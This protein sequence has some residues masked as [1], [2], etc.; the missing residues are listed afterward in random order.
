MVRAP[1]KDLARV[2]GDIGGVQAQL[3]SAAELQIA[4]RVDCSVEDVRKALWTDRTLVKTWLMRGTLHLARSGDLPF[5]TAAM[6]RRWI[7][8]SNSWLKFWKI[9]E[10]ELWE[11]VD[12]IGAALDGRP[13]TREELIARVGKGKSEELLEALR[14]GWGGMLKPAARNGRL[15]FG[16]NRGQSV[17][18][19]SPREWLP[20]WEEVDPEAG[21]VEMARR[22]LRAFGPATRL[23]FVRWWG[24]WPGVGNAAWSGLARELTQVSIEGAPADMLTA[25]LEVL[26]KAR[27]GESVHLLPLFDPYLLG[28]ANRDHLFERVHASKVSRTAGWISAVVLVNGRV[29]GTWTHTTNKGRLRV[30]VVPFKRFHAGTTAK[31]RARAR[32]IARALGAEKTEVRFG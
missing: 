9:T 22:Y 29:E 11:L 5:Y 28:Y 4:V 14:S 3:M 32:E 1:R 12:S 10:R 31:V 24:A 18:F 23:D 21:I 6:G 20:S 8:V 30:L 25:D 16:P 7:R 15:C 19:V 27:P 2:V 17:T 13:K 26:D